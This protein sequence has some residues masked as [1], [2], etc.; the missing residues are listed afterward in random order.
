[1]FEGSKHETSNKFEGSVN[2]PTEHLKVQHNFF[3]HN[4]FIS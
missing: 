3:Q 1:M 4:A 2:E